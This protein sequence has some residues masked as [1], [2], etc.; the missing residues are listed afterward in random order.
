MHSSGVDLT[1]IISLQGKAG[2]CKWKDRKGRN[3]GEEGTFSWYLT[4]S[5]RSQNSVDCQA[6]KM[7]SKNNWQTLIIS[8]EKPS[9]RKGAMTYLDKEENC[10]LHKKDTITEGEEMNPCSL[11][12]N[13]KQQ[14]MVITGQW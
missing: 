12:R 11:P 1:G 14:E 3:I 5:K 8:P 10:F 4:S 6:K 9:F 13:A 7:L 2:R